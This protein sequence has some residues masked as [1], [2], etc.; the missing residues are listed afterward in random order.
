MKLLAVLRKGR[1][2]ILLLLLSVS[3]ASVLAFVFSNTTRTLPSVQILP[4]SGK[5]PPPH[6]SMF[7]RWIPA[8]RSWAWL[9]RLKESILGRPRP[10]EL[11][12]DIIALSD[13]SESSPL[14]HSLGQ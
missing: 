1:P 6:V 9:W 2:A 8:T 11:D 7:A 14:R 12:T 4:D 5:L 3:V 10:V 13:V